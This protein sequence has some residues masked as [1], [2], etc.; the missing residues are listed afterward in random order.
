MKLSIFQLLEQFRTSISFFSG[1]SPE[2]PDI[3]AVC[4]ADDSTEL[5]EDTVYLC[6]SSRLAFFR[7]KSLHII[8]NSAD[9]RPEDYK[10]A[11]SLAVLSSDTDL[12]SLAHSLNH[13]FFSYSEWCN[14]IMTAALKKR[15]LA[16]ILEIGSKK[17]SNPLALFDS[18]QNLLCHAGNI[19]SETQDSLW[20]FVL[21]MGYSP[22][23][24]QVSDYLNEKIK[25]KKPFFFQSNNRFR[26][27]TRIIAPVYRGDIYCGVLASSDTNCPF[28]KADLA[29]MEILRRLIS[30]IA[31]HAPEFGY[32]TGST[33][34]FISQLLKGH[35]LNE[36]VLSV[37]IKKLG[38]KMSD[39][40]IVWTFQHASPA[41]NL[42]AR[43]AL[44]MI[45]ILFK[46]NTV[47]SYNAQIVVIDYQPGK[48]SSESFTGECLRTIRSQNLKA[49][50][51]LPFSSI[52]DLH[53]A[54]MQSL[55]ALRGGNAGTIR[56]FTSSFQDYVTDVL[57]T[58]NEAAGI[59]Y[60]GLNHLLD[61]GGDA[62][63]GR[64][65]LKCLK[66]YI[67]S[68]L[69]ASTTARMLHLHRNTIQYRLECI[70]K[71]CPIDFEHL[72]ENDLLLIYLSCCRLM[73]N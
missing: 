43:Q 9:I 40:F 42:T 65:L 49:G 30:Q 11:K 25:E 12:C 61:Y 17:F 18:R 68:G 1:P 34:W 60:P 67:L 31:M 50:K 48:T 7:D 44:Q 16:E 20:N 19:R 22:E 32:L 51:S 72:S 66:A 54:F 26:N 29:T 37:N 13:I 24:P 70:Q 2:I 8:T 35:A 39:P 45:S 52:K 14:E 6:T 27:I 71:I 10:N 64:E 4:L 73:N 21:Q 36:N 23:E 69:N 3:S 15:P 33:P 28:T 53:P 5:C 58:E 63:Y 55:I 41:E 47:Y 56:E 46:Q 57:N 38:K 62:G 59:L